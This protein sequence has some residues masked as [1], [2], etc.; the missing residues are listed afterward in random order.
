MIGDM[1][2]SVDANDGKKPRYLYAPD[3]FSFDFAFN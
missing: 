1:R 2:N 3:F